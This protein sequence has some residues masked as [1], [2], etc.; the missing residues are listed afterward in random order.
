MEEILN[1]L[2]SLSLDPAAPTTASRDVLSGSSII[3]SLIV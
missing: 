3:H 1:Q 2:E